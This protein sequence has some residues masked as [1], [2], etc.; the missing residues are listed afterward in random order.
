MP[1][2]Y[3]IRVDF[4][5]DDVAISRLHGAAFGDR[6]DMVAPWAERLAR[7]SVTW[8]GAFAGEELLAFA[9]VVWDGG[10]HGFLLDT[11]VDPSHQRRGLGAAV[12]AAV[13]REATAAGCEWLHVDFE[14]HLES[15]YRDACGFQATSAGLLEL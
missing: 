8:A 7:H 10:A 11:A 13:R 15:F 14:P 4:E 9:H 12:V 1:A 2:G 5:P 3:E 6:G